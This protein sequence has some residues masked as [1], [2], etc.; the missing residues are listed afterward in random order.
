[1]VQEVQLDGSTTK[2]SI[3]SEYA[4][5]AAPTATDDT[6]DGFS[7]G[8]VWIDTTND[9]VY[10]NVDAT[11][12]AAVWKILSSVPG[13]TKVIPHTVKWE[14]GSG[15]PSVVQSGD[16]LVFKLPD[17]NIVGV[18]G[19][20]PLDSTVDLSSTNPALR[21]PFVVV[22]AGTGNANIRMRLSVRYIDVTELSTKTLDETLEQTVAVINTVA[23]LHEFTF[24][25]D[26]TLI[27]A[28]DLISFFLERVG[29]DA[30][31][32]FTGEIGVVEHSSF[33]IVR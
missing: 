5:T 10:Q 11:A 22:T 29:T 26:K 28:E 16:L 6:N 32:T 14:S 27:V 30:A 21:V 33:E 19:D 9:K 13:G 18:K 24:T 8:S 25:L 15:G 17:G 31:D 2:A 20:Y 4:Q 12:S 1:M 7:V 23:Q 3:K